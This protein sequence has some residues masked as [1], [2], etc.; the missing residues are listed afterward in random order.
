MTRCG[1]RGR[2]RASSQPV[3]SGKVPDVTMAQGVVVGA[4]DAR[5]VR[6]PGISRTSWPW[7]RGRRASH[8]LV[9]G[10]VLDD[11]FLY[12]SVWMKVEC[13]REIHSE[14]HR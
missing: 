13:K 8:F 5:R 4:R 3:T 2:E 12:E 7:R 14:I 10:G 11:V 1:G 6:A 9:S